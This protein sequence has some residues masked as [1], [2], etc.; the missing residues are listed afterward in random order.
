MFNSVTNTASFA[1]NL[2]DKPLG[3]N[4]TKASKKATIFGNSL[5]SGGTASKISNTG[6]EGSKNQNIDDATD[7]ATLLNSILT[8]HDAKADSNS[9][10]SERGPRKRAVSNSY[11]SF[12]EQ[13]SSGQNETI[14]VCKPDYLSFPLTSS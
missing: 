8:T 13:L 10:V 5:I 4:D 12:L 14:S 2:V 11:I 9:S 1:A 7:V 6:P 3:S